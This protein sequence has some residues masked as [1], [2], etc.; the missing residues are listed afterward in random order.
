[1]KNTKLLTIFNNI[2]LEIIKSNAKHKKYKY[3]K[4]SKKIKKDQ[5]TL[6]RLINKNLSIF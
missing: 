2:F 6:K 5:K 3:F 4:V 1:M